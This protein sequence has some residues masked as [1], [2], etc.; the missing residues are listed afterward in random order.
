[1]H[2]QDFCA[3]SSNIPD[4]LQTISPAQLRS[5]IEITNNNYTFRVFFHIIRKSNG[6]GGQSQ[7][8][9]NTAL[10][11]LNTDYE[12]YGISFELLG[13]DEIKNDTYYNYEFYSLSCGIVNNEYVFDCDAMVN[14]IFFNLTHI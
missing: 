6:T 2:A 5:G 13:T 11:I 8:D 12:P 10:N 4:I 14:L 7:S 9:V 3:T 1:M